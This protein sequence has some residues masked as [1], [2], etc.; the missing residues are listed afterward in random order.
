[1]DSNTAIKAIRKPT[2]LILIALV[3]FIVY[4]NTFH[5]AFLMDE[6]F[7]IIENPFVKDINTT[8]ETLL[9]NFDWYKNVVGRYIS[10]L[11]FALNYRFHG[12]RVE[13][14]H[15]VNLTIHILNSMLVY[16]LVLQLFQT[17]RLKISALQKDAG[18]IALFSGLFFVA[19]PLQTEAV[20][21]VMERPGL[22]ATFFCLLSLIFYSK[23]R[24][25]GGRIVEAV[26][27]SEPITRGNDGQLSFRSWWYW[28]S[29]FSVVLAMKSRENALTLPIIICLY[30]I[31]FFQ[32][33]KKKRLYRLIP[34]L[35]T[36]S[37]I[38]LSTLMI[39]Q[40]G[41]N[42]AESSVGHRGI[43]WTWWPYFI[44]ELRVIVTYYRLLLF[45]VGQ[46]LLHDY[47]VYFSLFQ[48]EIFLSLAL[49]V[50]IIAGSIYLFFRSKNIDPVLC[51]ISFGIIFFYVTLSVESGMVPLS[52]VIFEYRVYMP[53]AG[54]FIAV[55]S[56]FFLLFKNKPFI[57][58]S[59][60]TICLIVLGGAAYKRNNLW[61]DR[62]LFCEDVVKKSPLLP[63]AH[64]ALGNAYLSTGSR[65]DDALR[66]FR[67]LSKLVEG[68]PFSVVTSFEFG[69]V[70]VNLELDSGKIL[71][72]AGDNTSSVS[73]QSY[74]SGLALAREGRFSDA[75]LELQK[76]SSNSSRYV[77]ARYNLGV[78]YGQANNYPKAIE[79]YETVTRL[80]ANHIE[81]HNN[82]AGLYAQT[83]RYD[84]A[85]RMLQRVLKLDPA[86]EDA[87][88]NLQ[89]VTDMRRNERH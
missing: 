39:I 5:S 77:E 67:L 85:M 89:V 28:G 27:V 69:N 79:E 42:I 32:G 78:L 68:T 4:S 12:E 17:P 25:A 45:P 37:I 18:Y 38:P 29:L 16:M 56:G 11:T 30:E 40:N 87:R 13:G 59:A 83:G 20:T 51:L 33:D 43:I 54:F 74:N 19:H 64:F 82:L 26:Y 80:N 71:H 44:N 3:G 24:L 84:E 76:V 2:A 35:S 86:N 48:P 49:H 81:A 34:L 65:Y 21:Y 15:V 1:M 73:E 72:K 22:I 58:L 8:A 31:I 47:P 14:Y 88:Y 66:E 10:F 46:N 9:E 55:I 75:I 41:F 23:W 57:S 6:K 62:V 52:N 36:M 60:L 7:F 61:G 50:C 63:L 70:Y 53:S